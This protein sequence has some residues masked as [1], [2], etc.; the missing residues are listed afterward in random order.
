[1]NIHQPEVKILAVKSAMR[2]LVVILEPI[3]PYDV[4]RS[5]QANEC[6]AESFRAFALCRHHRICAV[7]VLVAAAVFAR[8]HIE[9]TN[10][11]WLAAE[12][13]Q[14]I[15]IKTRK[16]AVIPSRIEIRGDHIDITRTG[17]HDLG[18]EKRR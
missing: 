6:V 5:D 7:V 3:S 17:P 16:S 11:Q 15:Q 12:R 14:R 13:V 2:R 1:M 8:S 9:F 18:I 4:W 10:E